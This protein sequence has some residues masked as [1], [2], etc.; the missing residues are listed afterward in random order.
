MFSKQFELM[1]KQLTLSRGIARV[2][3]LCC[4]IAALTETTFAQV[5]DCTGGLMYGIWND[6]IGSSAAT[7]SQIRSINYTTGA[8]GP[9]VGGTGYLIQKAGSGGPY[10]GSAG[11]ALDPV[12]KHF[13]VN[14]QMGNGIQKDFI[15]INPVSGV[16]TMIGSTPTVATVDVPDILSNYHFVKLAI[17]PGGIGYAIGVHRDT[18]L[19]SFT[20]AK[21]NPLISFTTCGGAPIANCSTI[22]LL[23]YLSNS[24][25][26]T[27]NY[28]LF[29][30]DIAFDAGGNLYF[31][32]VGFARINGNGR[33]TDARLF[34]ISSANIPLVVG[35]G[36][37]PLTLIADY[38]GL[39]S[40]VVNGIAFNMLGQMFFS[41]RVF[42]GPQNAPLPPFTNMIYRSS[43]PGTVAPLAGFTN[44]TVGFSIA[45]LASCNFPAGVLSDVKLYLNGW[46]ESGSGKLK[47]DVNMNDQVAYYEVEASTNGNDFHTIAKINPVNINSAVASYTYTD[48]NAGTEKIKYYRLREAMPNGTR[49]Y[50]NIIKINFGSKLQLIAKPSPS[51]FNTKFDLRLELK[52]AGA[53]A[54]RLINQAG[55]FVY[56][57]NINGSVGEN[58]I[59]VD[60]LSQLSRGIYVVE[61]AVD[62]EIIRE[63]LIKQ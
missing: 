3:L 57:K 63:K 58:R 61:I 12:F 24:T 56:Q 31:L 23:G 18:T 11:L 29:N 8:V 21:C 42:S 50:S 19:G 41:T 52:T 34:R 45:D 4:L 20:S 46:N 60:G 22:K 59:S 27:T 53:I 9:L 17:S 16:M 43:V 62:E 44:P 13:F 48:A 49:Y 5:P 55:A 30:G 36:S 40:T 28:R 37:I 25:S 32:T 14:T 1:K 15:D 10:Y 35:T 26:M 54:I 7:A 39:D 38:N 33:Y 51:P 6:S 47:W 2:T